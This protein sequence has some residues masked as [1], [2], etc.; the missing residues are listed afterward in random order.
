MTRLFSIVLM[1]ILAGLGAGAVEARAQT[2]TVAVMCDK[3]TVPGV[4]D[5][6]SVSATVNPATAWQPRGG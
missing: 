2:A 3:P 4:Q 1:L 6:S 5:A